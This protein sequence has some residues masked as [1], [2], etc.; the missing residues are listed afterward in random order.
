MTAH[1]TIRRIALAAAAA[2]LFALILQTG[3]AVAAPVASWRLESF[4][5][6]TDFSAAD[7][8]ACTPQSLSAETVPCDAYTVTATDAGAA[9]T[10][11]SDVTLADTLPAGL[12]A[13]GVSLFWSG[14]PVPK[15]DRG[16]DR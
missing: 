12:T 16:H 3:S 9:P 4:A 11:G 2:A 8:A 5:T 7:N 13:K 10:D 15:G 6:P 14:F 1:V